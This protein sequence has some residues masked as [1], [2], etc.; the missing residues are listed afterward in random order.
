MGFCTACGKPLADGEV[1]TCQQ[2]TAATPEQ[3][4][5]SAAQTDVA[6][7]TAQAETVAKK[8]K[9]K[10][11]KV[12]GNGL[13]APIIDNCKDTI[14]NP[15]D[16]GNNY[17]KKATTKATITSLVT[18][19]VLYVLTSVFNLLGN[20]LHVLSIYKKSVKP[21]LALYGI[22]YG[23][24]LKEM[25]VK[26]SDLL[27]TSGITGGSWVQAIFFPIIYMVLMGAVIIGLVYVVNQFIVKKEKVQIMNV[28]KFCASVS[29]P[30]SVA[31]VVRFLDGFVHVAWLNGTVL[32]G[33]Y[34]A[35]LLIALL[36]AFE[37]VRELVQD[38]KQYVLS[39]C[40][41]VF[42]IVLFNYLVG[43]LFLGHFFPWFKAVPSLL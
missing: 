34:F 42:G 11:P 3:G 32:A 30:I 14:E 2:T 27:R 33:I 17:Y 15:L 25:G 19:A 13:F 22:K 37:I 5:Y 4:V 35:A 8:V 23:D 38:K 26:R 6:Q 31:L 39:L 36:Q 24:Y 28:A 10:M 20:A 40:V 43:T 18:L 12:D 41:M 16:A 29:L 21:A 1:C 7:G 9:V